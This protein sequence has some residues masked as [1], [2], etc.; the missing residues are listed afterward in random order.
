MMS[1]AVVDTTPAL[2]C[3]DSQRPCRTNLHDAVRRDAEHTWAIKAQWEQWHLHWK[4]A[5]LDL[6]LRKSVTYAHGEA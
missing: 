3:V 2:L 6:E 5:Q 1:H 4:P